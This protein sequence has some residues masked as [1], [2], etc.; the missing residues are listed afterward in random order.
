M[1]HDR[2]CPEGVGV[3]LN[4]TACGQNQKPMHYRTVVA[5]ANRFIRT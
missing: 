2:I 3:K 4:P 5:V 1:L